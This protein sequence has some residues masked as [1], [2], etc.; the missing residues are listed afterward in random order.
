MR[1]SSFRLATVGLVAAAIV[2]VDCSS[3]GP[4]APSTIGI[5]CVPTDERQLTFAGF[6]TNEVVIE[7]APSACAGGVCLVNHFQ[8]RSNCPYGQTEVEAMGQSGRP[9]EELCHAPDRGTTSADRVVVAVSPQLIGR[10]QADVVHCSCRCAGPDPSASYCTCPVGFE[11]AD[12]VEP[13][14]GLED[15]GLSG[16]YCVKTGTVYDP[17]SVGSECTK[18]DGDRPGNCGPSAR[19][20]SEVP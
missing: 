6:A 17:G 8:G 2:L 15:R 12:L 13:V 20:F 4:T 19:T 5:P 7:S 3:S 11:C 18:P 1:A 10:R 9:E 16:S 14:V